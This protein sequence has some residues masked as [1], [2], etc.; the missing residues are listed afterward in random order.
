M[1]YFAIIEISLDFFTISYREFKISCSYLG[2]DFKFVISLAIKNL[3][4]NSDIQTKYTRTKVNC[5]QHQKGDKMCIKLMECDKTQDFKQ[6]MLNFLSKNSSLQLKSF[7]SLNIWNDENTWVFF[8]LSECQ[9]S[10]LNYEFKLGDIMQHRWKIRSA[11]Q[12]DEHI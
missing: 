4:E 1:P 5:L 7:M 6:I 8:C 3:E 2:R 10:W 9:W 11:H 12:K